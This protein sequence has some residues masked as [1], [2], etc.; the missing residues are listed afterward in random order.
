MSFKKIPNTSLVNVILKTPF[1]QTFLMGTWEFRSF[2]EKRGIRIRDADLE[3]FEE[4]GL[5]YPIVRIV[6][7]TFLW[8]KIKKVEN[9]ITKEYLQ[10]LEKD[11]I[12]GGETVERYA[13]IGDVT[14][15]L[16]DYL[17]EEL[18]VFPSKSNFKP[19]KEYKDGYET[20]VLPFYHPYQTFCVTKILNALRLTL[21]GITELENDEL[22]KRIE[23]L[24]KFVESRRK[25]LVKQLK[26]HEK[27]TRLLLSIQDRYLPF[28]RKNFVGKGGVDF[29]DYWNNW[30]EWTQKFDPHIVFKESGFTVEQ[31]KENTFTFCCS[32]RFY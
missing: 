24:R 16:Y 9:G 3:R 20:T 1:P 2:L 8:K 5:L 10:P 31:L 6:R 30:F 32:S 27:L 18:V 15:D 12:F 14:R 17:Q 26:E 28:I 13:M 11:E 29:Y 23:I 21:D 19:W 4:Q 25:S 7:S 22:L